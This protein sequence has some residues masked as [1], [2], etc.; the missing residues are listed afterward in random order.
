MT[1]SQTSQAGK[2]LQQTLTRNSRHRFKASWNS[3]MKPKYR[4]VK[5][6]IQTMVFWGGGY[7]SEIQDSFSCSGKRDLKLQ[8]YNISQLNKHDNKLY[9]LI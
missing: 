7:I 1:H 3:E 4:G 9:R 5:E 8:K 2:Q 6:E